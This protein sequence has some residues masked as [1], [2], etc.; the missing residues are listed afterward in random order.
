LELRPPPSGDFGIGQEQLTSMSRE[1][2]VSALELYGGA[3]FPLNYLFL[4]LF[5]YYLYFLL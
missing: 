1:H 3:S 2:N 5:L 4:I